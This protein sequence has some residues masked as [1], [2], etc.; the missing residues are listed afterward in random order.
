MEIS[1]PSDNNFAD[2][3]APELGGPADG[4]SGRSLTCRTP[5][6]P[7][8]WGSWLGGQKLQLRIIGRHVELV[9]LHR[10]TLRSSGLCAPTPTQ[11]R[12]G[13]SRT[14]PRPGGAGPAVLQ[15]SLSF[16][17]QTSQAQATR[18]R[19]AIGWADCEA[20]LRFPDRVELVLNAEIS[21]VVR[22]DDWFR[23]DEA[24]ALVERV[25]PTPLLVVVE[26]EPEP[27]PTPY[28]LRGAATSSSVALLLGAFACAV[29]AHLGISIGFQEHRPVAVLIGVAFAA[30]VAHLLQATRERLAVPR[31][32]RAS[33]AAAGKR[34]VRLDDTLT[35]M[36]DVALRFATVGLP[37]IGVLAAFGWWWWIGTI[38]WPFVVIAVILGVAAQI[39]RER[40]ERRRPAHP[41]ASFWTGTD[42]QD[43]HRRP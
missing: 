40:R 2:R 33:A 12:P 23:G 27:D 22:A 37:A 5:A 34:F 3:L 32:W 43:E 26:G 41:L 31:K 16:V 17:V 29:I 28:L 14:P 7:S 30:P 8:V 4:E 24:L 25:V 9:P 1:T 6:D 11:D 20:V 13:A 18:V 38:A 10:F 21:V 42:D 36:P 19:Q 35:R 39:E 15:H